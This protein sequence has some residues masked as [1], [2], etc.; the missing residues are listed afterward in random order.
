MIALLL[1]TTLAADLPLWSKTSFPEAPV[2][3]RDGW[4]GGFAQDDWMSSSRRDQLIPATD[5]NNGDYGGAAYGS[6]WAADN[7]LINGAAFTDGRVT[8]RVTNSDD[9]CAGLVLAHNGTNTFY[10]FGMTANSAPPPLRELVTRPTAF[11]LRIQGGTA[12]ILREVRATP[13]TEAP[14]ELSLERDGRRLIARVGSTILIDVEEIG[15]AHV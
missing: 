13:L 7:W 14:R 12:T 11:L 6:G 5:Y 2:K 9:D 4:V 15:R 3:G 1:A 10:L 8:A